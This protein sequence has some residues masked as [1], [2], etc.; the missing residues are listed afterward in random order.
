MYSSLAVEHLQ[1][2]G[3]TTAAQIKSLEKKLRDINQAI[4]ELEAQNPQQ[5]LLTIRR[6]SNA[7]ETFL[8]V[9]Y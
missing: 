5:S 8:G 7:S 9:R 1:K 2:A 3:K 6:L 4:A